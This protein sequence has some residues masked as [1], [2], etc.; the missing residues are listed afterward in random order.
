MWCVTFVELLLCAAVLRAKRRVGGISEM[1]SLSQSKAYFNRRLD[2][3]GVP[4]EM[5]AALEKAGFE[6]MA[7]LAHCVSSN[8]AA[9]DDEKYVAFLATIL[10]KEPSESTKAAMRQALGEA[11]A[12][13]VVELRSRYDPQCLEQ[14]RNLPRDELHARLASQQKRLAGIELTG[15]YLPANA[16][17]NT[18]AN[19]K[20]TGEVVYIAPDKCL[21]RQAELSG[22]KKEATLS[23]NNGKITIQDKHDQQSL[24][25]DGEPRLRYAWT[26]RGLAF[27]MFNIVD[28]HTHNRWVE[29]LLGQLAPKPGKVF[30]VA[31]QQVIEADKLLWLRV[32][33]LVKGGVAPDAS[34]ALPVVVA[35]NEARQDPQVV[36]ALYPQHKQPAPA[37]SSTSLLSLRLLL[38]RALP[39]IRGVL[40]LKRSVTT[41]VLGTLSGCLRLCLPTVRRPQVASPFV[42]AT[43]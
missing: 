5:Q 25:I 32:A 33:E 18:V 4:S 42:L 31:M 35:M 17:L 37:S 1:A 16:L 39:T 29:F 26:R 14:P 10:E 11:Q 9:A 40:S 28:F 15:E 7:R 12:T 20:E 43:T 36:F 23:V 19:M 3:I 38:R 22:E 30:Q 24:L 2:E 21:S 27:D 41:S 13:M 6:S 34:G 8:P